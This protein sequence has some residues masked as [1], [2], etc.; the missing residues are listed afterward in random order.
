MEFTK[1]NLE[2][3]AKLAKIS[4][5]DSELGIW[6]EEFKKLL[7]FFQELE[8][9]DVAELQQAHE[10]SKESIH[11]QPLRDDSVKNNEVFTKLI[12]HSPQSLGKAFGVPRIL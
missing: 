12:P 10:V 7:G 8:T 11:P 5:S 2:H 1:E 9:L 6:T 4:I 3:L